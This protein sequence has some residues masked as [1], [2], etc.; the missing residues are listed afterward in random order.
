MRSLP[1]CLGISKEKN[2]SMNSLCI[3]RTP[4]EAVGGICRLIKEGGQEMTINVEYN[5]L[6]ALLKSAGLSGDVA[7]PGSKHSPY[8][9]NCN[10]L[11][12]KLADYAELLKET[13]GAVPEFVNPK[14]AD[15]T[16]TK[17]K[18]ATRVECMMQEFARLFK[19]GQVVGATVLDRWFC[20]ST[21]KNNIKDAGVKLQSGLPGESAF[22][23]DAEFYQAAVQ[24]FEHAARKVGNCKIS[25][26][27][28]TEASYH[29]MKYP[30]G[31][32]VFLAPSFGLTITEIATR[33]QGTKSISISEK[34][35]LVL[36]G[37]V[38][39]TSLDLDGALRIGTPGGECTLGDV[40]VKNAGVQAYEIDIESPA[41]HLEDRVRG[42]RLRLMDN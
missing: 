12:F 5:Q 15:A 22:T 41:E 8:P 11:V 19:P 21:V 36:E 7:A 25:I 34:S 18:S 37:P 23:A 30:I 10:I 13:G 32:K 16:K 27:A 38:H 24:C 1:V 9:G 2:Y 31:P 39:M 42:Y 3:P 40:K 17:F 29:G 4:G 35:A 33:L 14:Y 26:A 28:P 6:D 20:F